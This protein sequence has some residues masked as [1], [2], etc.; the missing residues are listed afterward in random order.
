MACTRQKAAVAA[1]YA[2]CVA[3]LVALFAAPEAAPAEVVIAVAALALM[4]NSFM[5][6]AEC[7]TQ[8]GETAAA[9]EARRNAQSIKDESEALQRKF[10]V[11]H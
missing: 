1:E 6:L 10:G 3:D 8:A 7:L 5:D 9:D 2:I 11:A 4:V